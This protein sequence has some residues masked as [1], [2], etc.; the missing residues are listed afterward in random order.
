VN[1]CKVGWLS[2]CI[3]IVFCL[4]VSCIFILLTCH[5]INNMPNLWLNSDF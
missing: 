5:K 1:V 3:T 4:Q 2:F